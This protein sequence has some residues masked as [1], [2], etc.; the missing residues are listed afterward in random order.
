MY[1]YSQACSTYVPS[2]PIPACN[3]FYC[4]FHC[5]FT[6]SMVFCNLQSDT[7]S[8]STRKL[9]PSA[10]RIRHFF[11]YILWRL[12]NANMRIYRHRPLRVSASVWKNLNTLVLIHKKRNICIFFFKKGN[13]CIMGLPS[14]NMYIAVYGDCPNGFLQHDESC[15]KFFHST[16]ATWAEAMVSIYCCWIPKIY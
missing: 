7:L 15:Y 3:P 5:L 8:T 4:D 1:K 11:L 13:W 16:R 10:C 9:T 2:T 14:F 6:L 12:C